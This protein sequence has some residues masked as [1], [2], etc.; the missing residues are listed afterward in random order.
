M[1]VRPIY[2]DHSATTPLDGVVLEAMMPIPGLIKTFQG[3]AG[4]LVNR[5]SETWSNV[6]AQRLC[7]ISIDGVPFGTIVSSQYEKGNP[8]SLFCVFGGTVFL[9]CYCCLFCFFLRALAA[10]GR[11]WHISSDCF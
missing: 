2:L 10:L 7:E 5:M 1:P 6:P 11:P 8:Q 3:E 9:C 4:T